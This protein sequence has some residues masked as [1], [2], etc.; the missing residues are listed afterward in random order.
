[1]RSK[2]L[3]NGLQAVFAMFI[4]TLFAA[5]APAAEKKLHDFNGSDGANPLYGSL[6]RDAAGNFYGTTSTDGDSG[7]GTVFELTPNGSG[8][9]TEKKLHN[10]DNGYRSTDGFYPRAG[11]IF[12][13]AGNLYGTTYE[14]G[15][16]GGGTVFELTPNGSGGWTEKK[17]HNFG[18]GTDGSGPQATLIW[19]AAGNLYGTTTYGGS[20][21]CGPGCGTVFEMTPN[22]SGGW[23]EKK[24]HNFNPF[25]GSDGKFPT[26]GVIFDRAGNLYG[27]T[28]YGGT[29]QCN[30]DGCGMVFE[31]SPNGIGGWTERNLHNFGN[32]TDGTNPYAGLIF[33]SAGNL[34]GTTSS[35]GDYGYG[36]VF[37]MT[38]R[39]GGGWTEKKLH[40]FGTGTDGA[41][42][43]A[44]LIFDAAGNLYGV[45]DNGGDYTQGTVFEMTPN[46][47]GGW[48]EKKLHNFGSGT[49]GEIPE[50]GLIFD[51]DGNL[52]GTTRL[53]GAHSCGFFGCGTV[54]E[55]TP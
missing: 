37:E 33:D 55:V 48:T 25:N 6:I 35:G 21:P 34:Y 1:M 11:L 13:A 39:E 8:G 16:Y 19:D 14:G 20:A 17:L 49:D 38:P 51:G 24:L 3:S 23:T 4:V 9:W 42:P 30:L 36:T 22:G 28:T 32:G 2:S 27:T 53:G 41:I 54:F 7:G 47:S 10:F 31:V 40:N 43:E 26:G 5:S 44:S 12:D 50:G 52:Y 29:H 18:N 45:T 15:D 46:G